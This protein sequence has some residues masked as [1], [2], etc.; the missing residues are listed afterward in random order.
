[1][2]N[3]AFVQMLAFSAEGNDFRVLKSVFS[4]IRCFFDEKGECGFQKAECLDKRKF[5]NK[6]L[7]GRMFPSQIEDL[8]Q[9]DEPRA[10][11]AQLIYGSPSFGRDAQNTGA[12]IIPPKMIGPGILT[13]VKKRNHGP[14]N[15][16][17]GFGKI[18]FPV[19]TAL[20]GQRKIAIVIIPPFGAGK[21]MFNGKGV[22][23]KAALRQTILATT[24]GSFFN[25]GFPSLLAG[26]SH[27]ICLAGLI[28]P[29]GLVG[30]S[31]L[32]GK[33]LRDVASAAH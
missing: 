5:L 30:E 29:S 24:A 1:M 4:R 8:S 16:V 31:F 25:K 26:F 27:E 13:W 28:Q 22:R 21:D 7:S 6:R 3:L 20:T 32:A 33:G 18:I 12:V 23:R 17:H 15:R 9:I 14:G 19:I 11:K 2:R 10:V